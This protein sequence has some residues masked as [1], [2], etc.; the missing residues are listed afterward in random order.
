MRLDGNDA[1]VLIKGGKAC[2]GCGAGKMGLCKP[3]GETAVITAKNPVGARQWDQVKMGYDGRVQTK[4]YFL[5]YILPLLSFLIGTFLGYIAGF[6][7]SLP[8]IDIISGFGALGIGVHYSVQQLRR[9]DTS[10]SLVIK[11]I[12]SGQVFDAEF[13][14]EEEL[15]YLHYNRHFENCV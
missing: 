3:G 6:Y 10:N 12:I 7:F 5:G 1:V 13:K 8:L 11:K 4:A 15:R 2:K 9:L 14:N